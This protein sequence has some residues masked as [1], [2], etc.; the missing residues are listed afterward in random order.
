MQE[1]D[2]KGFPAAG[3]LETVEAAG[4]HRRLFEDIEQTDDPPATLDLRFE[5]REVLRLK[6]LRRGRKRDPSFPAFRAN[7]HVLRLFCHEA[8]KG[9]ERRR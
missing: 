2:G 9:R 7:G 4:E 5:A 8:F 3:G 6:L 1:V